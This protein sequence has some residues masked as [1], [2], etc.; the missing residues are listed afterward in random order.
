MRRIRRFEA[1][2]TYRNSEGE[3]REETFPVQAET[4]ETAKSVAPYRF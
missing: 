2:L 1:H 3:E 4:Y